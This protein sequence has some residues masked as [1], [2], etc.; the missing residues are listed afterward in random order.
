[1]VCYLRQIGALVAVVAFLAGMVYGQVGRAELF[2]TVRDPAGL[3]VSG[4][5]VEAVEQGTG[6]SARAVTPEAGQF[7]FFALPPGNYVLTVAKVRFTTLRRSG[8]LLRVADRVSLDLELQLGEVSESVEVKAAAPM[9]QNSEAF[10]AGETLVGT[11][12]L[13]GRN[14]VPL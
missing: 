10:V 13:D 3:A 2:G 11:L 4:A 6:L 7:H 8:V 9:L 1:M 5:V 14:F 12:P